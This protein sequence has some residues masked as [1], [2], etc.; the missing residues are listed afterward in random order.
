MNK[1]KLRSLMALH[2]DTNK[3]LAERLGISEKSFSNKINENGSQ[4]LQSEIAKI[5]ELY[6]LSDSDVVAIFFNKLVS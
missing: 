6:G 4:F 5:K 1:Q 2:G 3:T